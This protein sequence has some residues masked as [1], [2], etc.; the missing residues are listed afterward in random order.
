MVDYKVPCEIPDEGGASRKV[1]PPL[2]SFGVLL[3]AGR[4]DGMPPGQGL[5]DAVECA[6]G[7]EEAGWDEA[8]VT[9]HHFNPTV[10]GSSATTLAAY[11]LGQ[12]TRL[13]VGT[14]ASVLSVKHPVALAE[15]AALLDHASGGRFLLGVAR[16]MP[17]LDFE[18]IGDGAA[19]WERGFGESLD[20]LLRALTEERVS[21]AGEFFRF[22]EIPV[23]PPPRTRPRPPVVVAANSQATAAEAAARG[24]PMMLAPT[25]P[26]ERKRAL[27]DHYERVAEENGRDPSRISHWNSAIAHLAPTREQ[28]QT[29]LKE[30]WAGWL[31][32]VQR[33]A[34]LLVEPSV[35]YER[36]MFEAMVGFQPVGT[37]EQCAEGLAR[38]SERLGTDRW[39]LIVDATG[40]RR[41][42]LENLDGLA[43]EL[44]RLRR[45]A[46]REGAYLGRS[47]QPPP[48]S[49]G[50]DAGPATDP[51][52]SGSARVRAAGRGTNGDRK[53][54]AGG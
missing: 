27:L 7:A 10:E 53:G 34:P 23:V 1:P 17:T 4:H 5:R 8:W 14:A 26:D 32:A 29:E 51:R 45:A 54:V 9:E 52:T 47:G 48:T 49:H 20:I 39:M 43:P 42:T 25:S 35:R 19:R 3:F 11:L 37:P 2:P 12:T 41:R 30:R 21:A 46:V 6:V 44:E 40:E 22:P 31:L 33:G 28:A 50:G 18:V 15:E 13:R 38:S 24:L 36:A 16:G